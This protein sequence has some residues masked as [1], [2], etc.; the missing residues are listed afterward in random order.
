MAA[1]SVRAAAALAAAL[2]LAADAGSARPAAGWTSRSQL[3]TA[4]A[5]VTAAVLK[6]EVVV[7]GGFSQ[8]GLNTALVEAYSPGCDT[9]RRLPS[10][11]VAVDHAAS[12]ASHGVL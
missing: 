7:T 12:A 4:R 9:W 8:D 3:P 5:E 1:G 2:V 11:P 10:L 6:G